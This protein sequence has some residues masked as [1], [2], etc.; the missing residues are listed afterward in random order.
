MTEDFVQYTSTTLTYYADYL[1]SDGTHLPIISRPN[2]KL[3]HIPDDPNVP[4]VLATIEISN[5]G[6]RARLKTDDQ[7]GKITV[8]VSAM[9]SPTAFLSKTFVVHVKR[10]QPVTGALTVTQSRNGSIHH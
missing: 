9:A 6:H 4:Q 10:H 3:E 7:P 5:D 1:G 8:T 2:W